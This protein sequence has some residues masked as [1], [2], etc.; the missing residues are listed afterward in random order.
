MQPRGLEPFLFDHHFVRDNSQQQFVA[1]S[2]RTLSW[3]G[4]FAQTER[5]LG[6]GRSLLKA[7]PIGGVLGVPRNAGHF[8]FVKRIPLSWVLDVGHIKDGGTSWLAC[9]GGIVGRRRW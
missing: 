6:R 4:S 9:R 7:T 3:Y 5:I 2:V 1:M 8:E